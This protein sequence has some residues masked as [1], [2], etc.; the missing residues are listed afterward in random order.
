VTRQELGVKLRNFGELVLKGFGDASV[1][2]A[3]RPAQ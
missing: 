2:R 3:S 1:K